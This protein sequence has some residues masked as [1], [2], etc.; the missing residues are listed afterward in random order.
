MGR[1]FS[2]DSKARGQPG[3]EAARPRQPGWQARAGHLLDPIVDEPEPPVN[4]DLA[5]DRAHRGWRVHPLHPG[6]KR[7]MLGNWPARA[8]TDPEQ[9]TKWWANSPNLGVAIATGAGSNLVVLDVDGP[10]GEATLAEL[11]REHGQLPSTLEVTTP[12]GRHLYF[13]HP[14]GHVK[15]SDSRRWR[16]LDVRGDGGQVVAYPLTNDLEP[17]ELPPAWARLLQAEPPQARIEAPAGAGLGPTTGYGEAALEDEAR[18]VAETEEGSRNDRL[19]DAA[20]RMGQLAHDGE[21]NL[22]EAAAVLGDAG[23]TAGLDEGEIRRTVGSGLTAGMQKP[24]E[25][26]LETELKRL[27]VREQAREILRAEQEAARYREPP[28]SLTL[29]QEQAEPRRGL[30]WAIPEWAPED[31]NVG[32]EAKRKT[33]KTTLTGNVTKCLVDHLPFLGNELWTPRELAG[34]VGHWN[35]ELPDWQFI[36]WLTDM[37]I[38]DTKRVIPWHLRGYRVPMNVDVVVERC[39]A[40]LKQHDIEVWILDPRNRAWQGMVTNENDSLAIIDWLSAVDVIKR[41]AGVHEC[42]IPAHMGHGSG[43]EYERGRGGSG[44]GDSLDA[45]WVYTRKDD[46]RYLSAEG[47]DVHCEERKVNYD[48]ATRLLTI[49]E[50]NRRTNTSSRYVDAAVQIVQANPGIVKWKL[51]DAIGNKAEAATA[52]REAIARGLIHVREGTRRAQYH[53]PGP[54]FTVNLRD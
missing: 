16:K 11:E 10:T 34:N 54:G 3:K 29:E 7:P 21:V 44:W 24:R 30:R 41:E 45:Y 17:A 9:V 37:N 32:I 48:H 15:N 1:L 43:E 27:R 49:G 42:Y 14:G 19:N 36:E 2:S 38:R 33:G 18:K 46:D 25:H 22:T 47:R 40:W 28:A 6:S 4:L 13:R 31:G 35:Y 50:G 8:T 52:I 53:H 12:N 39:I 23:C 20:F 51:E 26:D 5:L